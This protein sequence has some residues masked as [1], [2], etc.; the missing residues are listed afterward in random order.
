[1]PKFSYIYAAES[2]SEVSQGP[3]IWESKQI[4]NRCAGLLLYMKS[5]V[6]T[7]V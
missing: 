1:M 5:H 3:G 7:I 4:D 6:K 2:R